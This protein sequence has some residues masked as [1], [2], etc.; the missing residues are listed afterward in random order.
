[1]LLLSRSFAMR[2]PFSAPRCRRFP[3]QRSAWSVLGPPGSFLLQQI[4]LFRFGRDFLRGGAPRHLL[5]EMHRFA[6]DLQTL[7]LLAL[8][9]KPLAHLQASLHQDRSALL[10]ILTAHF[11]EA[12]IGH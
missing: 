11:G 8:R 6:A 1:M 5:Q 9:R 7:S 4:A 10:E 3:N 2:S 12:L